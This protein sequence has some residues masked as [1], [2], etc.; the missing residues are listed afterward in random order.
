MVGCKWCKIKS[1]V[2]DEFSRKLLFTT[3]DL[4]SQQRHDK[5][6]GTICGQNKDVQP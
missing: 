4:S 5:S 1:D 6:C 2:S 3:Y